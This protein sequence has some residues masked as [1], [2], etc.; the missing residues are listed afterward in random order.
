MPRI[1]ASTVN[2]FAMLDGEDVEPVGT[3][4][5]VKNPIRPDAVGPDLVFLK[6]PFQ[7]LPL[8]GICCKGTEGFFD[9]VNCG[10]IE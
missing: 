8:K 3:H 5:P 1:K 9:S 10:G 6:L 2:I 4:T 7:R